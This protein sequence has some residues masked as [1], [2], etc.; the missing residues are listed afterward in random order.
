MEK[1]YSRWEDLSSA[2]EKG[3]VSKQER[4]WGFD[5]IQRQWPNNSGRAD[6]MKG[7]NGTRRWQVAGQWYKKVAGYKKV[8]DQ[9][10]ARSRFNWLL[11]REGERR[12]MLCSRQLSRKVDS[13]LWHPW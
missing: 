5:C 11:F 12:V 13:H 8:E 7:S 3:R 4:G 2:S 10:P 1:A 9:D 6:S